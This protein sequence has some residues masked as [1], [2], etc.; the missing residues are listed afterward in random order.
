VRKAVEWRHD[1]SACV[2]LDLESPPLVSSMIFAS[3]SAAPWCTS[4]AGVNAVDIRH[5]ILG[6]AMTQGASRTAPIAAAATTPP[7]LAMNLRRSVTTTSSPDDELMV[8]AFR[9][10]IPRADES[11]ELRE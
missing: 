5:L 11:L 10:V 1:S 8:G 6:C 3:R 7:A 2:D 9:D 4:S